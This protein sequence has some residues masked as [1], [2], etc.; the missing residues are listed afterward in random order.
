MHIPSRFH[1]LSLLGTLLLLVSCGKHEK[2][3]FIYMP[4]MTYSPAFK[5]QEA[6]VMLEPPEHTVARGYEPYPYGKFE[7]EKAR[8]LKNPFERTTAALKRGQTMYNTYCI[9]CHG[10]VGNGNGNV[11]PKYPR[12]P[13]LHSKKVQEWPDGR[14]FHV[15]TRGQNLMPSYAS[16]IRRQDRWKIIHYLRALQKSQNPTQAD[17]KK[18]GR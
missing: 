18:L 14:I 13:S 17:F 2:P 8:G 9:V 1:Y 3:N 4:D 10:P 15:I 5:A 6:G 7:G 11:I 12:P 16:Q